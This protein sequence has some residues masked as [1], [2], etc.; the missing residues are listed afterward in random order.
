MTGNEKTNWLTDIQN[1]SWE[2]E[3]LI[4]GLILTSIFLIQKYV[5][6]IHVF[7]IQ[8]FGAPSFLVGFSFNLVVLAINVLKIT[9]ITHLL[10]RGLWTGAIG[11][12]YVY[13]NGIVRKNLKT[14]D[15]NLYFE[16][17]IDLV[18]RLETYCSLVFS[19]IFILIY[20]LLTAALFYIP[21]SIFYML[22]ESIFN[23][24]FSILLLITAVSFIIILNLIDLISKKNNKPVSVFKNMTTVYATNR[25]KIIP[26]SIVLLLASLLISK[27]SIIAIGENFNNSKKADKVNGDL[28]VVDNNLYTMRRDNNYRIPKAVI[29]DFQ[30]NKNSLKVFIAYYREDR[31]LFK[32][33]QKFKDIAK[34]TKGKVSLTDLFLISIDGKKIENTTWFYS[35]HVKTVQTGFTVI[36][37]IAKLN[38]GLHKLT[39]EKYIW[40][41]QK[42]NYK[43]ISPWCEIP[44]LKE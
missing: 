42:Q 36:I 25:L 19:F 44:F 24:S 32:K 8:D 18:K 38:N 28:T 27:N 9:I 33:K 37:P 26:L 15:E 29:G 10:M 30:E 34:F 16:K 4:S 21:I 1:R 11:L 35:N 14:K 5:F 41:R 39:I 17:P 23:F 12:S 31:V 2:P 43:L 22:F 6:N 20:F 40:V 3:I 13:P 7:F